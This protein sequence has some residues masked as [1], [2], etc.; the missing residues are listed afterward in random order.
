M[1]MLIDKFFSIKFTIEMENKEQAP[2]LD[3]LVIKSYTNKLVL[4]VFGKVNPNLFVYPNTCV[5]NHH[6]NKIIRKT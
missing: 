2:F 3:V 1:S 5:V 4:A 6:K